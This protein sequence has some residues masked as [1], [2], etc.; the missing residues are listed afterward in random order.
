MPLVAV[1]PE[2]GSSYFVPFSRN[3]YYKIIKSRE[4]LDFVFK[5]ESKHE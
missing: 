5:P 4:E 3:L 1:Q 2:F